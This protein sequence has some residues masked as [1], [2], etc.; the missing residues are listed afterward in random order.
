MST[1]SEDTIG[2]A[3]TGSTGARCCAAPRSSAPRCPSRPSRRARSPAPSPSP[4]TLTK[5]K[6]ATNSVAP[7]LSPVYLAK[8]KGLFEKYGLDVE[9]ID[10]GGSTENL[11]EALATGKADGGVGMALRW[12]KALE[13]GFDV[14]I[15][16]GSHG[17]CTPP[18]RPRDR[19]NVKTLADLKGK[20]IGITDLN[21][22]G[23]HFFS[24]L[25]PQ[26]GHRPGQGRRMA[27]VSD[28][29]PADRRREGRG[30]RHRRRRS[31][32]LSLAAARRL[33]AD[34]LESRPRLRRTGS[35]ASSACAAASCATIRRSRR[36]AQS[37]DP[38][39]A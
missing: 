23:K 26:G 4:A 15:T 6:F 11:L 13:A 20:T 3:G 29:R 27:A 19:A 22:P 37:R 9:L 7:C 21:S 31:Q 16:A 34:R 36:R 32:R 5:I 18:R 39:S 33:V 25:L 30:P 24:I 1:T 14:K 12:L 38:R 2:A 17:G 8:E 28:R 10:F 35:A